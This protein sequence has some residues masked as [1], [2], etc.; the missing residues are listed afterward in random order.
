MTTAAAAITIR[1]LACELVAVQVQIFEIITP[2]SDSNNNTIYEIDYLFTNLCKRDHRQSTTGL[3]WQASE[4]STVKT[5]IKRPD[6]KMPTNGI[7]NGSNGTSASGRDVYIASAFRT[8]IGSFGGALKSLKAPDLA[9]IAIS[10]SYEAIQL[11]VDRVEKVIVG[12]A[13]QAGS[14]QAPAKQ[15]LIKAGLPSSC[16]DSL[17]NEVCASG[18][19]A[20]ILSVDKIKSGANCLVA[21][22][23]ESMS[24]MP[25]YKDRNEPL[26]SDVKPP[27]G[28]IVDGL[29]DTFNKCHMGHC[30]EHTAK[31][32][33]ITREDQ[34]AYAIESYRRAKVATESGALRKEICPVTV[35]GSGDEPATV[36]T[37]DEEFKKL[38]I[39]KVR[40]LR[41]CFDRE[42][43]TITAANASSLSDGAAA[44]VLMS[45][46]A[47]DKLNIKPLA[48]VISYGE[49]ACDPIDFA[50]SPIEAIQDALQKAG[51]RKDDIS[52]WEIN[53]AF[54]VVSLAIMKE[55]DLN[56]S[57]VNPNGGGVSIGHPLG[58]SGIRIVNA[59]VH[60]LEPGQYGCAAICRGGGGSSAM[61]VR[62]L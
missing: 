3:S 57:K 2:D 56:H 53:E 40:T 21:A 60:Q 52:M 25:R 17:I 13:L 12:Q 43:G 11:P 51:L 22:G 33:N 23:M 20:I 47:V 26:Q 38:D 19:Q 41:P 6:E 28:I 29:T 55:L 49:G 18:M 45:S 7:A 9:A 30:A 24:N 34:D 62:K 10:K 54:S 42:S 61:I 44:C 37:D 58:M 59:L 1:E 14:G 27:C 50:T 46:D 35:A 39:E 48:R 16:R 8:P 32:L 5:G 15:A 31:K 36:V 4:I